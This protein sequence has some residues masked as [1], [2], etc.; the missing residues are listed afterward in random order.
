MIEERESEAPDPTGEWHQSCKRSFFLLHID[1]ISPGAP[2]Y[3][4]GR[5]S[6]HISGDIQER[7]AHE[8]TNMRLDAMQ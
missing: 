5:Y 6:Y 4:E 1:K 7:A 3:G 8:S 2:G